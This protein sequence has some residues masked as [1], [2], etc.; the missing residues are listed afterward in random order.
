MAWFILLG[1]G[2]ME[3][4]WAVGLKYTEGFT[5]FWPSVGT[6]AT[7]VLSVVL[8]GISLKSLPWGQRMP[9]GPA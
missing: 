1:A 5:R 9:C 3:V 8:L 2:L 4:A 7:M 6:F